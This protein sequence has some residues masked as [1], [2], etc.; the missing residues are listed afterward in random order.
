MSM[1]AAGI[2]S[3][4]PSAGIDGGAAVASAVGDPT[5]TA[6]IGHR[7]RLGLTAGR[8]DV[9]ERRGLR[10]PRDVVNVLR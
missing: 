5:K 7:D 2:P 4:G 9:T 6:A 8:N 10:D 3:Q 1:N